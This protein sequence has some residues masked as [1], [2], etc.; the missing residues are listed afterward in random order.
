VNGGAP[1]SLS[2]GKNR[3]SFLFT[4][5]FGSKRQFLK[6]SKDTERSGSLLSKIVAS[7]L[8]L[9]IKKTI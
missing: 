2:R 5:I 3:L 8:E 6:K 9:L 4:L 1:G 7:F